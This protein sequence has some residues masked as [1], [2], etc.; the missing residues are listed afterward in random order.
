MDGFDCSGLVQEILA[1]GGA[2]PPGDFSSQMLFNHFSQ[3]GQDVTEA[4]E[5]GALAF[6]GASPEKISHVAFCVDSRRMLE[7]G[8]G[9]S[10]VLTRADAAKA[11]AYC[12]VRPIRRNDQLQGIFLPDYP[13][14]EKDQ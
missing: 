11:N 4:P 9:G 6:Y 1:A 7:E 12:R 5:V 8:G 14:T 3:H 2:K 13:A 10:K